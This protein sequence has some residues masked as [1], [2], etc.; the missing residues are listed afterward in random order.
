MENQVPQPTANFEGPGDKIDLD[1]SP[2]RVLASAE[3]WKS[4]SDHPRR[5]AVSGF[6]FGGTN[7]HVLL[8]EPTELTRGRSVVS[9]AE[10]PRAEQPH[11]EQPHATKGTSVAIVGMGARVGPWKNV[12]EVGD[13]LMGRGESHPARAK[14]NHWGLPG[15]PVGWFIENLE[16][17]IGR[18]KITPRGVE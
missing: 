18:F 5:A 14:V 4:P 11:A 6:G 13:R 16:I 1:G 12:G 9:V 8:E 3:P 17:P 10:R 7:A 2:F 15:A